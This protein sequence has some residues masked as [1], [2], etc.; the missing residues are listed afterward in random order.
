MFGPSFWKA[1]ITQNAHNSSV[2][3][4]VISVY[5]WHEMIVE[6]EAT[7]NTFWHNIL[8]KTTQNQTC[9]QHNGGDERIPSSQKRQWVFTSPMTHQRP[10]LLLANTIRCVC[11]RESCCMD[12]WTRPA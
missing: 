11:V 2:R 5:A 7:A 8:A 1:L 12:G 9:W 6:R 4:C 3:V 10:F